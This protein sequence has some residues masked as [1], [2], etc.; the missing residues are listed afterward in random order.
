MRKKKFLVNWMNWLFK[1]EVRPV[2]FSFLGGNYA[3]GFTDF[4]IENKPFIVPFLLLC[5]GAS[6]VTVSAALIS[7]S[8][9]Y[10]PQREMDGRPY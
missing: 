6:P 9:V 7:N 3:S 10:R 8:L 2:I 1:N 4:M 5:S